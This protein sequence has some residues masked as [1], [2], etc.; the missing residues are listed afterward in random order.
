MK[1]GELSELYD[2]ANRGEVE[3]VE[4]TLQYPHKSGANA[5]LFDELRGNLSELEKD[6][7]FFVKLDAYDSDGSKIGTFKSKSVMH[8]ASDYSYI[9]KKIIQGFDKISDVVDSAKNIAH[10]LDMYGCE[11]VMGSHPYDAGVLDQFAKELR[12]SRNGLCL[13]L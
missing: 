5:T 4:M 12:E 6:G 11:V 3:N 9:V 1:Y 13:A 7:S 8:K 10:N 2:L